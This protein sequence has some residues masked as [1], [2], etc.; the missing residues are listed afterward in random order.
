[1]T[2]H[3]PVGSVRV[4]PV[5][6]SRSPLPPIIG[7][8]AQLRAA[9]AGKRALVTR[10]EAEWVAAAEREVAKHLS[11]HVHID[12]RGTWDGPTYAR[13]MLEAERVE[14]SFKPRLKRLLGEIDAIERVLSPSPAAITRRTA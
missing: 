4:A 2:H 6:V 12:D 11:S 5:P 7:S 9:L 3:A 10:L 14:P 1:M 13:Y 8:L